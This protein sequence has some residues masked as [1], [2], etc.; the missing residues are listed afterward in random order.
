[1][2]EAFFN[3]HRKPFEL[4]P[5]PDFLYM[6]GSHRRALTYLEYGIRERTGFILITGEVGSG[7]TT[8]IRNL[9]RTMGDRVVLAKIFNTGGDSTQLLSLIND[10]FGLPVQGKDKVCLLRELNEFLIRQFADGKFPVLIIDEAQNLGPELLEEIRMLSNLETDDAKLLQIILVGQP[11]LAGT[12]AQPT[13]L[14]LRQRIAVCCHIRPLSRE[15]TE[16]YIFHRLEVAGDRNAITLEPQAVDILFRYSRG[17]PRLINIICDFFMLAAFAEETRAVS[18]A[19]VREIIGDLDFE[20]RYWDGEGEPAI[21][22]VQAAEKEPIMS[23][24]DEIR[25]RL[26]ELESETR[27]LKSAVDETSSSRGRDDARPL[28]DSAYSAAGFDDGTLEERKPQ[29]D[30]FMKRIFRG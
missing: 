2:Y 18:A 30:T 22:G 21:G 1:M 12:L 13:L 28:G 27:D 11:E 25:Q 26:T 4:L 10:D 29:R 14:Q 17:I 19:L 6:S 7:K 3:L 23:V 15:E 5:N 8:L 20:N 16:N 9:I 24:L